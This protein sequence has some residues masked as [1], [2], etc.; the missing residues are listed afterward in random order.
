MVYTLSPAGYGA[1][2]CGRGSRR[3][4]HRAQLCHPDDLAG[5]S[6]LAA[7]P[8]NPGRAALSPP[9]VRLRHRHL[10]DFEIPDTPSYLTVAP[11]SHVAGTKVLP[12]P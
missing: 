4:R 8:A 12:A 3:P 11:I 9:V 6:Y 5:L 2:S 7:P 10:A 1:D